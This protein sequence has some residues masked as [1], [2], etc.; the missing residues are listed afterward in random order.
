MQWGDEHKPYSLGP[1]VVRRSVDDR[2]LRVVFVDDEGREVP[3]ED[4][5]FVRTATYPTTLAR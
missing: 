1:T 5:R 4:V 2:P 3:L